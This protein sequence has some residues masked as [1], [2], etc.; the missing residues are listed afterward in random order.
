MSYATIIAIADKYEICDE[1]LD[2]I[3]KHFYRNKIKKVTDSFTNPE[4]TKVWKRCEKSHNVGWQERKSGGLHPGRYM[5]QLTY[6]KCYFQERLYPMGWGLTRQ[7]DFLHSGVIK[8]ATREEDGNIKHH[9]E[10]VDELYVN[11]NPHLQHLSTSSRKD[12]IELLEFKN[13]VEEA[14]RVK[15]YENF[16]KNMKTEAYMPLLMAEN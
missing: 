15:P 14:F 8:Y 2:I 4:F 1:V 12:M 16:K 11:E 5:L 13:K 3:Y 6:R 7:Q 9:F 10:Y